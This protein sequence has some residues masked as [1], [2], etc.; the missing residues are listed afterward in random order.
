MLSVYPVIVF[1]ISKMLRTLCLTY[2]SVVRYKLIACTI[3]YQW[4]LEHRVK[5]STYCRRDLLFNCCLLIPQLYMYPHD[6]FLL[7]SANITTM[8]LSSLTLC[9][10]WNMNGCQTFL[11][12]PLNSTC[13]ITRNFFGRFHEIV[14]TIHVEHFSD[15]SQ[16]NSKKFLSIYFQVSTVFY[17]VRSL[18]VLSHSYLLLLC[19]SFL[20]RILK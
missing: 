14:P 11:S 17:T 13:M 15:H 12:Q 4:S 6:T 9:Y 16:F 5:F 10:T 1:N 3:L 20:S 18:P 8:S 7:T 19:P 2:N